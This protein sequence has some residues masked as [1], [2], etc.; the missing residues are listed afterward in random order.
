MLDYVAAMGEARV[1]EAANRAGV[2]KEEAT[3]AVRHLIATGRLVRFASP[4]GRRGEDVVLTAEVFS[5]RHEGPPESLAQRSAL[6]GRASDRAIE[7]LDGHAL[8]AALGRQERATQGA[9]ARR[10]PPL[11]AGWRTH[12]WGRAYQPGS[13]RPAFHWVIATPPETTAAEAFDGIEAAIEAEQQGR[14]APGGRETDELRRRL[15]KIVFLAPATRYRLAWIRLTKWVTVSGR[16]AIV[17]VHRHDEAVRL[18]RVKLGGRAAQRPTGGGP[19]TRRQ[20][21][22]ES[23]RPGGSQSQTRDDQRSTK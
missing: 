20:T 10:R 4:S 23:P 8:L 19:R 6:N 16:A 2:R 11:E 5:Q 18:A 7:T 21:G 17:A 1:A 22:D 3:G 9:R 12:G 14:A 15:E 13:S